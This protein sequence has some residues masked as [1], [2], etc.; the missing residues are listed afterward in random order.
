M[1]TL[2][3]I[4]FLAVCGI[5]YPQITITHS[6]YVDAWEPGSAHVNYATPSGEYV[7][8]FVGAKSNAP[9]TWDFTDYTIN[10]VGTGIGVEPGSAPV[11]S[12]FPDANAVLYTKS[13]PT[14]DTI[15]AWQYQRIDT[16]RLLMYGVSDETSAIMTYSPPVVQALIP[17][18]YGITWITQRDSTVLIPPY[19]VITETTATVDAFGTLIIPSGSYD[20]LRLTLEQVGITVTPFGGD[21]TRSRSYHFYTKN[22]VE[23]NILGIIQEQF[24]ETTIDVMGFNFSVP[25]NAGS[26]EETSLNNI[27]FYA[28]P[29]PF[30][31]STTIRYHLTTPDE[32]SLKICD[33]LGKEV[34]T[35]GLG[36]RPAGQNEFNINA[37][38]L[39]RGVYLCQLKSGHAMQSIKLVL[40]N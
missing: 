22:M 3:L 26:T 40:T 9:Q 31:H 8:V 13:Y 29:N 16:D 2:F 14:G 12:E 11:I 37:D 32:I 21:T 30:Q 10:Q 35:F 20:C 23:V 17:L 15:Y 24:N 18:A 33:Y 34:K 19:Y 5:A 7:S 36:T 27:P 38:E 25:D 1:R 28:Y 39:P 6:D 4:L